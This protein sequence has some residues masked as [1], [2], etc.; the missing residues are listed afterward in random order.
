MLPIQDFV[1][2]HSRLA[3]VTDDDFYTLKVSE[4]T[5]LFER[6]FTTLKENIKTREAQILNIPNEDES[7]FD[8]K[9]GKRN[10]RQFNLLY[11]SIEDDRIAFLS[12]LLKIRNKHT[13]IDIVLA[14]PKEKQVAYLKKLDVYM[15]TRIHKLLTLGG[16]TVL[17]RIQILKNVILKLQTLNKDLDSDVITYQTKKNMIVI[18][19]PSD[20]VQAIKERQ[21]KIQKELAKSITDILDKTQ[22]AESQPAESPRVVVEQS[23]DGPSR[24]K[25][26]KT[27]QTSGEP[28]VPPPI[29]ALDLST[30][31]Q[32]K[33][34]PIED[35]EEMSDD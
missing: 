25:K 12:A 23:T 21:L 5:N 34:E 10:A 24:R 8:F 30:S 26:V 27:S 33:E 16:P 9:L 29:T 4:I 11:K 18:S 3:L 6:G 7:S 31:A 15:V 22:P 13:P 1:D 17:Q 35:D 32:V 14:M 20:K 28:S 2:I 19:I